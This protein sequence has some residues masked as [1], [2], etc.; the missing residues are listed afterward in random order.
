MLSSSDLIHFL[1]LCP[2]VS[3]IEIVALSFSHGCI[4]GNSFNRWLSNNLVS[5]F[6]ALCIGEP[7]G[8]ESSA[9]PQVP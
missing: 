2:S 8:H 4:E 6:G 9:V 1:L 5:A 7:G 3:F